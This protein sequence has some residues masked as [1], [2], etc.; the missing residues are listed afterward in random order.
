[1]ADLSLRS[2]PLLPVPPI[3]LYVI[4]SY[5][6]VVSWSHEVSTIAYRR[7]EGHLKQG[8]YAAVG[9]STSI[10]GRLLNGVTA[11]RSLTLLEGTPPHPCSASKPNK[12][13]GSPKLD[14]SGNT[15]WL[16]TGA[17]FGGADI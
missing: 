11:L 4:L 14:L 1:M 9:K 12:P 8:L 16:V 2:Q 7:W 6:N 13:T 3:P 10:L 17:L 5:C 15:Q